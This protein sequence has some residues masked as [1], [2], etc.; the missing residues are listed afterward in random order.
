[1]A[2]EPNLSV[3]YGVR[4]DAPRFNTVPHANTTAQFQSGNF[5]YATDVV[6]TTSQFSPRIGFNWD[7]K[8]DAKG[9]IRGGIGIFAGRTPYVWMSNQYSNT[10]VDF[11]K[12]SISSNA[13]NK[14]PFIADATAQSKTPTGATVAVGTNDINLIDPN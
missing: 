2:H 7:P 12:I 5:G 14:I 3:T 4:F 8:G 10:G 9:Q 1:M 13:N 6:P 11:T